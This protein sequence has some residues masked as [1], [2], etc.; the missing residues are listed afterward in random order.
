MSTLT[1][2]RCWIHLEREAAARCPVC[3]RFYCRECV[4]EHEG[5]VVC[6]ACLRDGL[7]ATAKARRQGLGARGRRVL[8]GVT[9]AGQLAGSIV[10]AF[11][12]FQLLGGWLLTTATQFHESN[13]WADQFFGGGSESEDGINKD[14]NDPKHSDDEDEDRDGKKDDDSL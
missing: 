10:L 12:F 6:A 14:K 7:A 5:K 2:Q 4:T 9:R 8:A 3:T 13:L 1:R 11:L